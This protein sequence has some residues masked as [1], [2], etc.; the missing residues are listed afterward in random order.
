SGTDRPRHPGPVAVCLGDGAVRPAPPDR[1]PPTRLAD[2][3]AAAGIEFVA[4]FRGHRTQQRLMK[5]SLAVLTYNWPD[6]L[7]RVLESIAGQRRMP[8]EILIA[9]DGSGP[10]TAAVISRWQSMLPVP[11]RHLWQEDKG[12]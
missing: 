12:F 3:V 4:A 6:A 1:Q 10:A 8:D 11:V 2:P 7:D 5:I 9:D